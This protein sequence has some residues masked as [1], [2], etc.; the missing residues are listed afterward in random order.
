ML[1]KTAHDDFSHTWAPFGLSSLTHLASSAATASAG[2]FST[3]DFTD[4]E[5]EKIVVAAL[6]NRSGGPTRSQGRKA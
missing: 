3:I 1:R 5:V 2:L 6:P 4:E